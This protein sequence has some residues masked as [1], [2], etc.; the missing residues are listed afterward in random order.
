MW[1]ISGSGQL[2]NMVR[3]MAFKDTVTL[4]R[5]IFYSRTLLLSHL[6]PIGHYLLLYS[7]S[8]SRNGV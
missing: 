1:A 3:L 7:C 5:S 2:S 8:D 6:L 4:R